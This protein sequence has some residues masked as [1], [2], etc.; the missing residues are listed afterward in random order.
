MAS[1]VKAVPTAEA[2]SA[3]D[4]AILDAFIAGTTRKALA[5]QHGLTLTRICQICKSPA[6]VVYLAEQGGITKTLIYTR[7]GAEIL[8]RTE[9]GGMRLADLIA[10]WKAAMPQEV[11]INHRA[12][13]QKEAERIAAEMGLSAE[14]VLAEAER[15]VA[16][17]T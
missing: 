1:P 14:E 17:A 10:I 8:A 15:I 13:V 7:V 11:T 2:L 4:R 12:A 3:R 5:E 16:G 9:W 6:A